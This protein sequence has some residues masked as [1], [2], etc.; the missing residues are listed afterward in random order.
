M[1]LEDHGDEVLCVEDF[2]NQYE[3]HLL[4]SVFG[5]IL[6]GDSWSQ[7]TEVGT[8]SSPASRADL[9]RRPTG[10]R[11]EIV[12]HDALGVSSPLL[13][14]VMTRI[15]ARAVAAMKDFFGIHNIWPNLTLLSE[16]RRG[17]RHPLHADAERE[18]AH[19][20][21]PNH[22]SWRTHL[23]ILY[24]STSGIDCE[25]GILRLPAADLTIEPR[26]G[27]FVAFPSGRRYVHEVTAV[28]TGSRRSLAIWLTPDSRYSE[29][30]TDR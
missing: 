12:C 10:R 1:A 22:T 3:I 29:P 9:V 6:R 15:R 2:A 25:G 24:L 28:E 30:W 16:M 26:T 13:C 7:E 5:L 27:R 14:N 17:D 4:V 11:T 21:V 19:G 8:G 20:W 23:G 18:T